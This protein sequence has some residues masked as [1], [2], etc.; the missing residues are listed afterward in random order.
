MKTNN[1]I[2]L[3][4]FTLF[5]LVTL[6]GLVL[7]FRFDHYRGGIFWFLNKHAWWLLHNWCSVGCTTVVALHLILKRKWINRNILHFQVRTSNRDLILRRRNDIWLFS[8]F[9]LC[10][11]SGFLPWIFDI[12]WRPFHVLHDKLGLVL[13]VVF[14]FHLVRHNYPSLRFFRI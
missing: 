11:V 9:L 12:H 2:L 4:S 8:L 14:L 10:A 7:F 13:I 3:S 6:S 1:L 5:M